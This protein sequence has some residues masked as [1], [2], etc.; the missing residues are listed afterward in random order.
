MGAKSVCLNCRDK[1]VRVHR[2]GWK[3]IPGAWDTGGKWA[4]PSCTGGWGGSQ[5]GSL[6]PG[7]EAFPVCCLLWIQW[8]RCT[9]QWGRRPLGRPEAGGGRRLGSPCWSTSG[10]CDSWTGDA[11]LELP[12]VTVVRLP[13]LPWLSCLG[14]SGARGRCARCPVQRLMILR[15]LALSETSML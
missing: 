8:R 1:G 5:W 12:G 4:A 2:N 6:K 11:M 7:S 10:R 3:W 14:V 9:V 13:I 15:L